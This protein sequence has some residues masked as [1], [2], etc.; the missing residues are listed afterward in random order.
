MQTNGPSSALRHC[1]LAGLTLSSQDGLSLLHGVSRRD[2][3]AQACSD[4]HGEGARKAR[5]PASRFCHILSAKASRQG[6]PGS[7]GEE[8]N[9]TSGRGE[10][11]KQHPSK[12]AG[13][14]KASPVQGPTF[15]A[16]T[17][18]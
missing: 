13:K 4:A 17:L 15:R 16:A 9:F 8:L 18:R 1:W 14:E 5:V 7:A 12:G 3:L 2:R 11:I 6:Q 10:A